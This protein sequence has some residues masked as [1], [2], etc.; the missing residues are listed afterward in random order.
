MNQIVLAAA[1][2]LIFGAIVV[3]LIVLGLEKID[4]DRR[5]RRGRGPWTS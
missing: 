3:T 4:S 2:Q 5:K 1:A